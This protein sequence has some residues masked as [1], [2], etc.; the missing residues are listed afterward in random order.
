MQFCH[1][2]EPMCWQDAELLEKMKILLQSVQTKLYFSFQGVWTENSKNAYHFR[3]SDQAI[4]FARNNKLADVQFV[5]K[6][7][8]PQWHEIVPLPLLVA[9]LSPQF[10]A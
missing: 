6:F 3:H 4:D 7:E 2:H 8:D 5:V 10:S 1:R 9:T